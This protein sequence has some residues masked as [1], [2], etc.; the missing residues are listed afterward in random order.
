MRGVEPPFSAW[1]AD[2]LP[3][4]YTRRAGHCSGGPWRSRGGRYG[5]EVAGTTRFRIDP[6]RSTLAIDARSSVHPINAVAAPEGWLE[7]EVADGAFVPDTAMAG[8][9]EVAVDDLRTGNRLIDRETRRRIDAR[10]HPTISADLTRVVAVDG[11]TA[12]LAGTVAFLDEAVEVEGTVV[13]R[14]AAE[15][16]LILSGQ[17]DLDVRRWGLEPPRLLVLKVEPEISVSVQLHLEPADG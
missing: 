14:S 3:L 13:I 7:A 6:G 16:R 1:E 4:N 8:H 12:T 5:A 15:G 17:T 10:R 2:V 11:P 9:V